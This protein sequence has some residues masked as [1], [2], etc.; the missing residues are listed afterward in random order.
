MA[1][2]SKIVAE[3]RKDTGSTASRRLRREGW[4]PGVVN[5]DKGESKLI[6]MN[7]HDFAM[8]LHTHRSE[9]V[10]VDLEIDKGA[11]KKVLLKEV[12]HDPLSGEAQHAEFLE[13]SMDK[14]MRV[15]I[16]L[17]LVGDPVGVLNEGGILEHLLREIEIECLPGD[18][19]ESVE[20]DVSGMKLGAV[21]TAGDVVVPPTLTITTPKNVAVAA[22]AAPKAEEEVKEGE[23]AEGVPAQPEVI[24]EKE[25]AEKAAKEQ[26]KAGA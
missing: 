23:A 16:Q 18:L 12:Q 8:M 2:E 17:T 7:R 5:N 9:N 1:K 14:K 13:V 15:S 19:V 3:S 22:V 10:M 6:T 26:A 21:M 4:L 25:R 24:G 20:V 11:P